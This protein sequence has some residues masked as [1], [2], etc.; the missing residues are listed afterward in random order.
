MC[1]LHE[2]DGCCDQFSKRVQQNEYMSGYNC[3]VCWSTRNQCPCTESVRLINFFAKFTASGE[4]TENF[5]PAV[6]NYYYNI[7][8]YI[9]KPS[10]HLFTFQGKLGFIKRP[11]T[12]RR[13]IWTWNG[14]RWL[15]IRPS[16]Y[17][18]IRR[19]NERCQRRRNRRNKNINNRSK[20]SKTE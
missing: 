18:S 20:F 16:S 10:I 11:T 8:F 4:L 9:W 2:S 17:D 12:Y 19:C 7:F 13:I 15:R 14:Y 3:P 1:Y 6:R 5:S